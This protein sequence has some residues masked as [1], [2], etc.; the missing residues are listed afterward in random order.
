MEIDKNGRTEQEFLAA[1]DR[2]KYDRPSFTADNLL[3]ADNGDG[4]VVLMVKR[5]GH[6]FLGKW[7]LPGGFVN[8]DESAEAAAK[9]ELAEETGIEVDTAPLLTVSTPGRDPRG[10]TVSACFMG[11]LPEPIAPVA[12]DDAAE[13]R[14]FGVD[15]IATGDVYKLILTSGDESVSSELELVRDESGKI[16]VN[17]STVREQGGIAFDHAK[18]ILYAVESL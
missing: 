14:W 16:D 13:A 10:W 3:F 17:R 18:L 2:T 7:A 5:G 6:P 1:Y 8:P 4:L 11:L 12:G 9:R 15:Y